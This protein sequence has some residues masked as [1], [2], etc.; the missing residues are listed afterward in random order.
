MFAVL[1]FLNSFYTNQSYY[2][3]R[4]DFKQPCFLVLECNMV[5]F[6]VL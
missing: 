4:I 3:F 1:S 5:F 6:S 2:L